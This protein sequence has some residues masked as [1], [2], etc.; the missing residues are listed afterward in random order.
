LGKGP[1]LFDHVIFP[2]LEGVVLGWNTV[3]RGWLGVRRLTSSSIHS[4]GYL[5]SSIVKMT[6][7]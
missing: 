4:V 5:G 3:H 2:F 7:A 6:L 1:A